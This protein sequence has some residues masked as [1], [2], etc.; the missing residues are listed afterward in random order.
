M[1][2]LQTRQKARAQR[3][4]ADRRRRDAAGRRGRHPR[5][6]ARGSPPLQPEAP[7]ALLVVAYA[8]FR[9]RVVCSR[10]ELRQAQPTPLVFGAQPKADGHED[11]GLGTWPDHRG[12]MD[13]PAGRIA[14][15]GA[16][17]EQPDQHASGAESH[18]PNPIR[19]QD[20]GRALPVADPTSRDSPYPKA[21][22][23]LAFLSLTIII[24]IKGWAP[25]PC[26]A[27]H[28]SP[29]GSPRPCPRGVPGATI[30]RELLL[31]TVATGV[32][33]LG[34]LGAHTSTPVPGASSA[35]DRTSAA[36][37]AGAEIAS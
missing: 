26:P 28:S 24:S 27:I 11:P 1:D 2:P 9:E 13:R 7:D 36:P 12:T 15:Q 4:T 16:A 23:G 30:M 19:V 29:I 5:G 6:R 32:L 3:W 10:R 31:S 35:L 20:C 33:L 37:H 8:R 22:V 34:L 25:V 18:V 17:L 14:L 21:W